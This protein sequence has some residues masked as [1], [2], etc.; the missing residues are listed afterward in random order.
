MTRREIDIRFEL[1]KSSKRYNET[2]QS[3]D[4]TN[5]KTEFQRQN[6][7]KHWMGGVFVF[8]LQKLMNNK[9]FSSFLYC[10]KCSV[11]S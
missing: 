5:S 8:L 11:Y 3:K 7:Y 1:Q 9:I 2:E 4:S 10:R 6:I